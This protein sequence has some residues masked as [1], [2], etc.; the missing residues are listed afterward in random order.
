MNVNEILRAASEQLR[1]ISDAPELDAQ[2]LLLHALRKSEPSWL[3]SHANEE[4]AENIH[5]TF[6]SHIAERKTG[7]PLAYIL[8][9]AEFYGRSFI[10]NDD[11]LIPRPETE[12]LVERAL[13][14]IES[15]SNQLGR[16]LRVADIGTGS[17]CIAITLA[18]ES[19]DIEK[20]YATDISS[21]ALGVAKQ[22]AERFNVFDRIEFLSGSMLAPLHSKQIDHIISNPPYVPS[23]E[24]N[25]VPTTETR[26]LQFEPRIALD[27]GPDGNTYINVMK[28]SGIPSI[29]E[30]QQGL[31]QIFN[32]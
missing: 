5:Q 17:G 30:S 11:V 10:V 23:A 16:P 2:W 25:R 18:L 1:N 31:I 8:G 29:V 15:M 19:S 32:E 22:N 28:E 3:V 20:I 13:K 12:E 7:K 24:L 9:T 26:G 6:Q 14:K 4:I 27:G 21:D